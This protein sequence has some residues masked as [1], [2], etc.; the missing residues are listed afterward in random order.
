MR[1]DYVMTLLCAYSKR[2]DQISKFHHDFRQYILKAPGSQH[3]HQAW[4]GGYIDH[5]TECF[6][7][8]RATYTALKQIRPLPFDISSVFDVLY[9]HDVSK[10]FLYTDA[11]TPLGV[12]VAISVTNPV[13]KLVAE[14][15]SIVFTQ[16]EINAICYI[17]GE[18]DYLYDKETRILNELGAFCHS[19]DVLSA[20][21]WYN[22]PTKEELQPSTENIKVELTSDKEPIAG[23]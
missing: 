20:R 16:E 7:I 5:L 22:H 17:H 13:E 6:R 23:C 1:D 2:Y 21:M 12:N 8:A 10:L 15:Y 11:K 18:P 4:E 14:S 19:C 9:F 3:K